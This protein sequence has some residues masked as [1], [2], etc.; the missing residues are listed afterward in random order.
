LPSAHR[1]LRLCHELPMLPRCTIYICSYMISPCWSGMDPSPGRLEN[2]GRQ[3]LATTADW[4]VDTMKGG[5]DIPRHPDFVLTLMP[6]SPISC[7]YSYMGKAD[8]AN[9]HHRC[10]DK[11]K[12]FS[13]L[14]RQGGRIWK[15]TVAVLVPDRLAEAKLLATHLFDDVNREL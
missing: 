13:P 14:T 4:L 8:P 9:R 3:T 11:Q 7:S 15:A 10:A 12:P 1:D 6:C 5:G 2:V